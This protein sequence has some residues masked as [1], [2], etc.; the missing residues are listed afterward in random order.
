MVEFVDGSIVAQLGVP[1]MRVPIL[2]CLAHPDRLP[3]DEFEPFDPM[4][5]ASLEF[6]PADHE[7]FPAV[8]LAYDVISAGGDSGAVLNA[9]DEVMT[10]RFLADE[11]TRFPTIT[12]VVAEVVHSH[13]TQPIRCL[14][15]VFATDQS[16]RDRAAAAADLR[17]KPATSG[18]PPSS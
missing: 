14:A 3:F 15:D 6:A 2:Y 10:E 18:G 17:C 11:G 9:A 4:R 1:D 13:H 12:E 16:A 8:K 7:R 5:F